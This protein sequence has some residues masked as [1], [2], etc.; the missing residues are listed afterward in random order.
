MTKIS[1]RSMK[2]D[3]INEGR[4][5][6]PI[7]LRMRRMENRAGRDRPEHRRGLLAFRLRVQPNNI[8][9][10]NGQLG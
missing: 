1:K 9:I 2:R 3:Q 8:L 5:K 10:P 4:R 6:Q 7:R